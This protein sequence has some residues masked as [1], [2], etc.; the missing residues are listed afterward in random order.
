[1]KIAI[2]GSGYVGLVTGACFSEV[3]INVVC[4]DID[5]KKIEN[6]N[7]GIIPIYEPGLEDMLSRNMKKGRLS[8]TTNI[9]EAVKECEVLF[10]SVGTPPDEDGSADLK[11]VLS[12]ARDCGKNMNDY[13]LVVTKS[14]VPVGTSEKVKYAI[15]D[16]LNKR[17]VDIKFDV[18]SN[19][20]FL[21]EGAAIADF[22][23]PDR[24][25]IGLDSPKAEDLMKSLYKPFT[26]NGHPTI[27]MDIVSAEMTKYAANAMLA[28][29]I[30]FINDIANLCEIVGAD[31]NLVRRGIGSDSRIG[32]KFIYPGIGYGGS[33]FPK[34]VQALIRTGGEFNYNLRV[35]KAVEEVNKDQ[36]M[37]IFNK[38]NKYFK[39]DLAGKTIALW[40]LSFKPQTDDMR[41]APSLIIV[42]K[43]LEAGA[44]VKVYDPVA[45]KEAKHHFADSVSYYDDQYE[46]L[47][48]ADCL[49]ILTEWPEFKIPNL[50]IV[51]KLLNKPAIFDGRNI[52]DK[53]EMKEQGFEYFCIGVNTT[54]NVTTPSSIN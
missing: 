44:I 13:L 7:N 2:V 25:V 26:L 40:G 28:T 30:S 33:C 29:K 8:F 53:D 1:M 3:G 42:E 47:I 35:L 6:L 46:A 20:E 39:G 24:I 14:T 34:D 21:K 4:V 18:A 38:I 15:Q 5:S 16:E 48:D 23:K 51:H 32:H 17:K 22:L 11:Y 27:F 45:M 31:I 37:V 50:K 49:A 52:Y 9:A 41:E 36:K 10:I 19:P 54:K 12:V 43:L